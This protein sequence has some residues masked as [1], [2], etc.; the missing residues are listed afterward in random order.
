MWSTAAA[1]A[2]KSAFARA[3]AGRPRS[4]APSRPPSPRRSCSAS[5]WFLEFA[6]GSG[7]VAARGLR[8]AVDAMVE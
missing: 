8:A 3:R 4:L 2:P 5:F 1:G 7:G 6:R